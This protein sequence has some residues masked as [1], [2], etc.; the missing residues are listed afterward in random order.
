MCYEL[1]S[2][3]PPKN[4]AVAGLPRFQLIRPV[5]DCPVGDCPVGDCPVGDCPVGDC[6]VG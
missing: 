5:G 2:N 6:P 3:H 4:V 1:A